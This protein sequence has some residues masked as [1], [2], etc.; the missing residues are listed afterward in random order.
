MRKSALMNLLNLEGELTGSRLVSYANDG[1]SHPRQHVVIYH[2]FCADGFGAAWAIHQAA[3]AEHFGNADILYVPVTYGDRESVVEKLVTGLDTYHVD[4]H[5]V[6]FSLPHALFDRLTNVMRCVTYLDH[7]KGAESELEAARQ[8]C[9]DQGIPEHIVFDN[10]YSGCVLAWKHYHN[11]TVPPAFLIRIEDR[12][13]WRFQFPDTKAV[14]AAVYSYP[15][16]FGVWDQFD[17]GDDGCVD[18]ETE[19]M[20]ILRA[21]NKNVS[22]LTQDNNV[23]F[24]SFN[25]IRIAVVNCAWFMVSDVCHQLLDEHPDIDAAAG[26]HVPQYGRAKWSFRAR[27]DGVDLPTLLKQYGGGGHQAASGVEFSD[28]LSDE[29][30]AFYGALRHEQ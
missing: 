13:L 5:I 6:D 10:D 8:T 1:E 17:T 20:A 28:M 18:L 11:G 26:Y 29:A 27:K 15:M 4:I 19:G 16:D 3:L 14:A 2:A 7:H 21:H 23:S 25:G 30:Q 12:D 9:I 24:Y 22:A